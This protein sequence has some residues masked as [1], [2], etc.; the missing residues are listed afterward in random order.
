M[1]LVS[2][3]GGASGGRPSVGASRLAESEE[4]TVIDDFARLYSTLLVQFADGWNYDV[5]TKVANRVGYPAS[6]L[7]D[8]GYT[9]GTTYACKT[10]CP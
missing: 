7:A 10:T 2:V 6:W 5:D 3:P 8:V 1:T 4:S 9:D